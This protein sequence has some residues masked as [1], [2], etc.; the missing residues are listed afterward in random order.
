[1][2]R[3]GTLFFGVLIFSISNSIFAQ[4]QFT[5]TA[6]LQYL[7][8]KEGLQGSGIFATL[9]DRRGFVWMITPEGINRFDG[10]QCLAN[11]DIA[12]GVE[13]IG[14]FYMIVE[15]SRGDIWFGSDSA[16]IRFSYTKNVFEKFAVRL[17]DKSG[18]KNLFFKRL[19]PLGTL[20]DE[21]LLVGFDPLG[22]YSFN[23]KTFRTRPIESFNL[24][25]PIAEVLENFA[26]L[27]TA[28]PLI[29]FIAK[30]HKT[31]LHRLLGIV[32]FK[33]QWKVDTLP[34]EL[35]NQR[36]FQ[37]NESVFW[38][39]KSGELLNLDSGKIKRNNHLP[40]G[41]FR[42][43]ADGNRILAFSDEAV[44]EVDAEN[45]KIIRE[46]R[47]A[48]PT[49]EKSQI[50]IM[51]I[52]VDKNRNLFFGKLGDGL[53]YFNLKKFQLDHVWPRSE[54]Q[55]AGFSN[56][57]RGIREDN[58][59]NIWVL[60][61]DSKLI[62]FDPN[63]KTPKVYALEKS[64]QRSDFFIDANGSIYYD[65]NDGLTHFDPKSCT[66]K[67]INFRHGIRDFSLGFYQFFHGSD[68]HVLGG[69][70]AG[71][72]QINTS[73]QW[74]DTIEG[75]VPKGFIISTFK[76]RDGNLYQCPEGKGFEI[77]QKRGSK[78]ELTKSFAG[79]SDVK[80]FHQSDDSTVWIGTNVGLYKF[81]CRILKITRSY[82]IRD[83]LPSKM[84]YSLCSDN[85]GRLWMGT[86]QGI[87]VLDE[88]TGRWKHFTKVDGIQESEFNT[89]VVLKTRDG[90]I[91]FG[92]V[93][94]LNIIYPEQFQPNFIEPKI[95]ITKI[96]TDSLRNPTSFDEKNPLVINPGSN[97]LEFW[98]TAIE[99]S[100]PKNCTLRYR[101][102]G[103]DKDWIK[104]E[105]PGYARYSNLPA[106]NY[107]LEIQAAN[108]DGIWAKEAKKVALEVE[109][110]WYKTITFKVIFSIFIVSMVWLI[111]R[112][113]IRNQVEKEKLILEK[114]TAVLKERERI[115]ADLHDD[116]GS[117]LSSIQIYSRVAEKLMT[118]DPEKA[119]KLLRQINENSNIT[120][121]NLSDIV[122][123]M[124]AE[125]DGYS[126]ESRIK[127]YCVDLLEPK[128]IEVSFKMEVPLAT[129]FH[130]AEHRKNVLLLVKEALNNITKYSG[131][132]H[133]EISFMKVEGGFELL[134]KDDG[135]GF[136]PLKIRKGN[137]LITMET[138]AENVGGKLLLESVEGKGTKVSLIIKNN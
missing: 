24:L 1:M 8:A 106:G 131:A 70:F 47:I 49:L 101:I 68:G 34:F 96:K 75:I 124:K 52:V 90:R 40:S 41:I 115:M 76:D 27:T 72:F 100:D 111:L 39:L 12:P 83:G 133:V 11:E 53:V 130:D 17:Q 69:G 98:F 71:L 26:S 85:F 120:I 28:I 80:H 56:F 9:I 51:S 95:Q 104:T 94:G 108:S 109:E 4:V 36:I 6:H 44:Y 37:V 61:D 135:K 64:Q 7:T 126:M 132:K 116:V 118:D 113:I 121:N 82:G 97:I 91:I 48:E 13:E 92:G 137:G 122:W 129:F 38:L 57:F 15:D 20:S 18:V 54:A 89:H 30:E 93:N 46:I 105:N 73:Q 117:S 45:L 114:Q 19:M 5:Q 62:R 127:N 33:A 77:F 10:I 81:N 138:R 31:V 125:E 110:F 60:N 74:M 43:I 58:K 22:W 63:L 50:P 21:E 78:Y 87:S 65:G 59:G 35:Q 84:I 79:L 123:A 25:I 2:Q 86:G 3:I 112:Q 128:E 42:A 16:M 103:Y 99:Y 107:V 119:K 67:K 66:N 32:N 23:T 29:F 134:L 102:K 55:K 136:D 14:R 88:S